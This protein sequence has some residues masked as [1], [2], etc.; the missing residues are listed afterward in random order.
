MGLSAV[1]TIETTFADWTSKALLQR[2]DEL[3]IPSGRVRS[4]D[5]VCEWDQTHSQGQLV[6]V[7]HDSLGTLTLPGPP[8]RVLRRAAARPHVPATERPHS[9]PG[10][11]RHPRLGG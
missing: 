3:G 5:E 7:E 11:R 6:E 9:R 1:T 2:L 10:L 4:I 8:R